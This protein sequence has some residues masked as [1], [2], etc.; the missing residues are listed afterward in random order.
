MGTRT[1][2]RFVKK[3]YTSKKQ[4]SIHWSGHLHFV[5]KKL[6]EMMQEYNKNKSDFSTDDIINMCKS[7]FRECDHPFEVECS[8]LCHWDLEFTYTVVVDSKNSMEIDVGFVDGKDYCAEM[9]PEN[10][11]EDY[12]KYF[13]AK[14]D[15]AYS[16][17]FNPQAH[18]FSLF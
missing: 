11:D 7:V 4:L 18:A 17:K 9:W 5:G 2:I 15:K 14:P 10:Q 6:F 12:Y 3:N 13:M 1:V 8:D 16:V